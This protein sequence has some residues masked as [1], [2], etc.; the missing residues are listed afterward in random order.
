MTMKRFFITMMVAA[1]AVVAQAQEEN[2]WEKPENKAVVVVTEEEDVE[3]VSKRHTGALKVS[4]GPAWI[5][6]KMYVSENNYE[7]NEPGFECAVNYEYIGRKGWGLSVDINYNRTGYDYAYA[8]SVFHLIHFGPGVVY[9]TTE[10]HWR[11]S[12]ELGAGVTYCEEHVSGSNV[13]VWSGNNQAGFGVNARLGAEYMI[14]EKFGIGIDLNSEQMYLHNKVGL[15]LKKNEFYGIAH[16]AI[17]LGARF[18]Y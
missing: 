4:A 9:A 6:S 18:Y 12:A 11:L 14:S 1:V 2:V 16:S 7:R 8:K 13:N 3:S 5:T 15:N 10:G 17:L